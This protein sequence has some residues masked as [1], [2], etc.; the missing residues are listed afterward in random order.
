MNASIDSLAIEP[1]R[2][3][4]FEQARYQFDLE[5]RDFLKL[6]GGGVLVLLVLDDATESPAQDRR[7]RGFGGRG[8]VPREIGAWLHIH[9]T[10]QITVY[11][12]K[13]EVGQNV[14]T[15]LAQ[16][17]AEELPASAESI[18]L[19]MADTE[20]TPYDAGTFGSRSMPSMAPQLQR[21][22][23][24]AREAL[25]DLAT[26]KWKV[27]RRQLKA[28][29]GKITN[30]STGEALGFGDLTQG[31]KLTRV[32]PE[33]ISTSPA[34]DW[35]VA[36]NSAPKANGRALVTGQHQYTSDVRLPGM[37]HGKVLR[38]PSL[39]ATLRSADL[40][41][42][43]AM[44]EVKVI[45]DADFIAVAAPTE[46]AAQL[47]L[48]EIK[49][50]WDTAPAPVSNENLFEHLQKTSEA[51]NRPAALQAAIDAS[52][53]RLEATYT[54]AYIAHAP[55]E[56]RAAVA[57]WEGDKLTVWTGT[58][59]PFGVR[60]E[61]AGA[62]RIPEAN[63]RVITPDTGSGYGGKHSG[64]AAVEAARLARG[65]GKP[66]KLVWT[67]EEEFTWAYFRP[68]GVI[69]IASGASKDGRLTA[70]DFHNYN[71]GGSAIGTLYDVPEQRT[72]FHRAD[73]PLRQGSYRALASTANV[74]ARETHM[75]E[76]AH[77][78]GIEP[79]E[80]RL[81]NLKDSRLR[82]VFEAAAKAFGWGAKP[83]P[84]HG[85]GIGGG[86]EKGSYVATCAEVAVDLEEGDV[87][88]VRAVSAFDCGAVVNP[89]HLKNQIEGCM[90][91]GL[92]GALF[93]QIEFADG[94]ILN[95]RFS[96]Y[97]T[98][99][100]SDAPKIEVVLIDRKELPSAGAGETPIV[101]IAPA[102]GNAI[103]AAAGQRLRSLPLAPKGLPR[104]NA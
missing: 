10:G 29:E 60:S 5:R 4:L 39:R 67:R 23:A 54:L 83:E 58:Q 1:E 52:D 53:V 43:E 31:Q 98:P 6:L 12:G 44:P 77:A 7:R 104:P 70:W 50:E 15:A 2:Y 37:L 80:F 21:V 87:R 85:F 46:R 94:K 69:T 33:S 18:R 51:A 101:G 88:V 11:T 64:E 100:F 71:S 81:K 61:L 99:R 13:V 89:N 45:R 8:N 68:A 72:E 36:G 56:P 40:A 91:M 78:A 63:V 34:K 59:R 49:A 103:F 26:E 62:F 20:L 17:V 47:A 42:V 75:D 9:Q 48:A 73:S 92:G 19:V 57:H 28:A 86:F 65:A 95:P 32:V 22:A 27:D 35:K 24:A 66:V 102:I 96:K 55:L 82:A 14:R 93:E 76:L 3:E 97:R 79:L 41:A 25:L 90:M 30:A 84:N 74:F 16:I 38:P